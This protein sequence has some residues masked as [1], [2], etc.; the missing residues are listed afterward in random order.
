MELNETSATDAAN[1]RGAK[2]CVAQ[3]SK[4]ERGRGCLR[5]LSVFLRTDASHALDAS[6][7]TA[8]TFLVCAALR[9]PSVRDFLP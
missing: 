8:V 6:D 2:Q 7:Q 5:E 1:V 3:L 9:T 4:S